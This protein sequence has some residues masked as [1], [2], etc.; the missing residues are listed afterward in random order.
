VGRRI[1]GVDVARCL[2]LLGMVTAHVLSLGG[3]EGGWLLLV[4]GRSAALFAVLA[5][6][7]V[8]LVTDPRRRDTA[9]HRRALLVRALLIAFIGLFLGLFPSGVAVIL[10]Y[11]GVLFLLAL[12]VLRW[13]AR[14]LWLL[15]IGWA[16]LS[17]VVSLLVRPHLPAPSYQVPNP[18]SFADPWQL[19]TE[20]LFTG[21]YPVL[22]WGAYLF[23]GLAAARSDLGRA[24]VGRWLL[25]LGGWTAVLAL[26]TA[27]WLTGLPEARAA[28]VE[29]YDRREVVQSWSDLV[30]VLQDG[31]HGTT[32]TGSW[33]W[34]TVW[35]PHSGSIVDMVHTTAFS[36][37]VLGL[38]LT[39][40]RWTGPATRR[41][42][43][44]AFGAG[45]MTL[46]LYAGHVLVLS[47][48]D[49]VPGAHQLAVHVALVLA[50][51]AGFVLTGHRGPLEHVVGELSRGGPRAQ[52]GAAPA[53]QS[54]TGSPR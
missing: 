2:A 42:W 34:L 11:Y 21:Y 27:R 44:V 13:R 8:A 29:S 1:V 20:L 47:L 25:V 7:S 3:E 16:L 37:G 38:C 5:G 36:L 14:W 4:S 10:T 17:P 39:L 51:G 40:V 24:A 45:T 23:A 53:G 46:T 31:L 50:V 9:Y 26:G 19:V 12:P 35:S 48:P 49:D 32:P 18:L 6:V 41:A 15:A 43:Q 22:T 52:E 54:G 28:L 30:P 33:W